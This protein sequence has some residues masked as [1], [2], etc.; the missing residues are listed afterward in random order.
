M[1]GDHDI[2][3][4]SHHWNYPERPLIEQIVTI[5]EINNDLITIKEP[6][7][8]DLYSEWGTI[9]AP[10]NVL[11]EVGIERSPATCSECNPCPESRK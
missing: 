11:R 1:Y 2:F 5:K 8:H 3:I 7:L 9:L 10:V 4:G 6:L